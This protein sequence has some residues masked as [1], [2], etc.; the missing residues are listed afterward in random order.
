MNL[1]KPAH[2]SGKARMGKVNTS[3]HGYKMPKMGRMKVPSIHAPR[4]TKGGKTR[5]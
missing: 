1:F 4:L 2:I 5:I 3:M